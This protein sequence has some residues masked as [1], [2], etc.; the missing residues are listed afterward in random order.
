[1]LNFEHEIEDIRD[2][3][4]RYFFGYDYFHDGVIHNIEVLNDTDIELTIS[5]FR[6]WEQDLHNKQ[7]L[8]TE[9]GNDFKQ[10]ISDDQYKYKCTF[11]DCRYFNTEIIENG[12]IYLNGRFKDS[13]IVRKINKGNKRF[14]H[15]RIQ[16]TGG[17]ID[18]VFS[19]FQIKRV[20][21]KINIPNRV[22]N[23]TIFEHIR[24]K[25]ENT[26]IETIRNT[27]EF[28]DDIDK[29]FAIS[30]LGYVKDCSALELSIK[31]LQG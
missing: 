13:V 8:L 29:M 1:M 31:A 3:Y 12:Y 25:Y 27:A 22:S 19:K 28:G 2:R 14:L 30:Y 26:N 11:K 5:C 21:G 18:I 15:Y 6:E 10:H 20:L 24:R 4:L 23:I 17:Y 16:T 7:I 9:E